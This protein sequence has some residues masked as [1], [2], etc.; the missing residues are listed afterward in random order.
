MFFAI[1]ETKFQNRSFCACSL[2]FGF[3]KHFL[4]V[5]SL[6]ACWYRALLIVSLLLPL[7][8]WFLVM[9]SIEDYSDQQLK[10]SLLEYGINV[11]VTPTTRKV[12]ENKLRKMMAGGDSTPKQVSISRT[13]SQDIDFADNREETPEMAE[14]VGISTLFL[15]YFM[16]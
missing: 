5:L 12:C 6:P 11:P 14:G 3:H 2:E 8:I 10:E 13:P 1:L 15:K 7:I 16:F 9:A 4:R